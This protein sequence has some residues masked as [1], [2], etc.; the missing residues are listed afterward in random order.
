MI[1]TDF[2]KYRE[3]AGILGIELVGLEDPGKGAGYNV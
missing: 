1:E 3:V 2:M